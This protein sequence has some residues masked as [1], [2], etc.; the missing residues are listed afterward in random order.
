MS[1]LRWEVQF[2]PVGLFCFRDPIVPD[3]GTLTALKTRP[4]TWAFRDGQFLVREES[5]RP[6][7]LSP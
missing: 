5:Q 3:K 4:S 2:L 7:P 1:W 6:E